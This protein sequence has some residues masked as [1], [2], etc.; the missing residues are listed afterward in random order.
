[1]SKLKRPGKTFDEFGY[2]NH[3]VLCTCGVRASRRISHTS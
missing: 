1:M 3:P 2:E